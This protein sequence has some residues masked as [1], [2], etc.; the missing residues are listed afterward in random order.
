MI[1]RHAGTSAAVAGT[2][3]ANGAAAG[4][5]VASTRATAAC[6]SRRGTLGIVA[7][8]QASVRTIGQSE[9]S[10]L[11]DRRPGA[12]PI[13]REMRHWIRFGSAAMAIAMA[14]LPAATRGEDIGAAAAADCSRTSVGYTPLTDL[15]SGRYRGVQGGLYPKGSNRPPQRYLAQ[16]LAAARSVVPRGADGS[17]SPGGRIALLSIGMSNTNAEFGGWAQTVA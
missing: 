11:Q 1:P 3:V 15:G 17:P 16:G 2:A 13:P 14:A 4:A 7:T 8:G 9:R 5:A 6:R 12:D 10:G